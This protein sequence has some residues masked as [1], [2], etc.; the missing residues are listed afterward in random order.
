MTPMR[1]YFADLPH[2]RQDEIQRLLATHDKRLR[3]TGK[4]ITR[5]R[6]I[7]ATIDGL[8]AATVE[9]AGDVVKIGAA[10]E[11]TKEERDTLY[12]ALQAF[13]P[14]RKG[15]FEVFGIEVDAEW[16]SERKW[17]RILPTLPNLTD[18]VIADI[19][20][21]NGYYM[22]RMAHHQPRLVLGFEPYLHHYFAFQTLNRMAGLANLHTELLGVE[23]LGLF[24]ESF[25]T[26]FLMGI[27]YH[28]PSP[29]AIL[30]EALAALKPSG[31]LIVESQIIP[32]EDPV[33]LF[34]DGRYG[35]VPGT[36]FVP[37]ASCL[38][39]WLV[40]AGGEEVELIFS[41]PMDNKEQRR[42]DWMEFESFDDFMDPADSKRTVEGY[43][44]P[45][46][47]AF[48]AKRHTKLR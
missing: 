1:T 37:T 12:T 27:L 34:P 15:P 17:N 26:I 14:W 9:T 18:Q 3:G 28:H 41:H 22:F 16:R 6:E 42:T 36:Y 13:M 31:T 2:A 11:I 8:R 45:H 48:R 21:S 25:D 19:G 40:R 39:N 47:A 7:M 29:I 32:G 4:G 23:H 43:P 46:R 30:R 10:T 20:S 5:Y 35:K 24:P 38:R 33:A 44:A